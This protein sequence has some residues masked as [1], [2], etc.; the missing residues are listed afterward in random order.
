M[1]K[2]GRNIGLALGGGGAKGIAHIGVLKV[3]EA[4]GIP[5]DMVAGTSIGALI[6]ALYAAGFSARE[7]ERKA[8]ES[9][10]WKMAAKVLDPAFRGGFLKGDKVEKILEEWLGLHDFKYLKMPLAVVATS[11]ATGEQVIFKSGNLIKAI[12]ASISVP[13]VFKPIKIGSELLSDGGLS[14]PIPDDVARDL[15]ADYVIAVNLDVG[16]FDKPLPK[17]VN[18]AHLSQ[19]SINIMRYQLAQHS[20]CFPD[21]II[22]PNVRENGLVG[23][24]K[25]FNQKQ[26]K[27]IIRIGEKA[28]ESKL[29]DLKKDLS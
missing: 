20:L 12:R 29:S 4:N 1:D 24:N 27:R 6:G 14:N 18:W 10:N 5:V 2:L 3:L 8:L 28:A 11:L 25:F 21:L 19:R 13:I 23:W 15:G 9:G 7:I 22:Q 17:N 26:V 16:Y